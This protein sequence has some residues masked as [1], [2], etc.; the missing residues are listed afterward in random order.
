MAQEVNTV[1]NIIE[2]C[3][4]IKKLI[5]ECLNETYMKVCASKYSLV[6]FYTQDI[7]KQGHE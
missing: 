4:P 3:T 6:M 5:K 2:F 7:L 1:N